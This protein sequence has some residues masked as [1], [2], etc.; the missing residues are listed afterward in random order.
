MINYMQRIEIDEY[1]EP[2]IPEDVVEVELIFKSQKT[3]SQCK[4]K[5]QNQEWLLSVFPVVSF[6]TFLF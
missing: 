5:I 4:S 1:I 2:S 6:K 3:D